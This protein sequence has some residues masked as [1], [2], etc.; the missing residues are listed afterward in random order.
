MSISLGIEIGNVNCSHYGILLYSNQTKSLLGIETNLS[1]A[2]AQRTTQV[3]IKLN[4][5]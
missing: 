5:Y 2:Y 1:V 3:P 4:P